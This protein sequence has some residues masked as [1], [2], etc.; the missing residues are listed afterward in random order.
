MSLQV[1]VEKRDR[2][3]PDDPELWL[4]V[5]IRRKVGGSEQRDAVLGWRRRGEERV[6]E[7]GWVDRVGGPLRREQR[8]APGRGTGPSYPTD[9]PA[10]EDQP[11]PR[12]A[13]PV[14]R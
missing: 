9:V 13:G 10:P 6:G 7:A 5:R 3:A 1:V 12:S 14:A 11:R 4:H 2:R 8:R